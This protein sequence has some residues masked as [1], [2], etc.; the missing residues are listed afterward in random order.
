MGEAYSGGVLNGMAV[1][2][3]FDPL[4]RRVNNTVL[5]GSSILAR[6]TNGY[7]A[8]GRVTSVSDGTNS[9]T[10]S[11]FANSPLVDH[12]V[13]AHSGTSVMT[14]QNTY[15]HVNRLTGKNMAQA[16][17]TYN[18][19]YNAASQRTRVTLT[20]GDYWLWGFDALGQVTSGVKYFYDGTRYA[21]EQFGYSFDTIGNRLSTLAGGDATGSNLRST[22]YTNNLLNQI[23]S[24]NVPPFVDVLGLTLATNTVSVNGTNAYQKTEF[25]RYQAGANNAIAPQWVGINVTAPGQT[26]QSGSAYLAEN[27]ESFAYDADGN[28]T[29]D[30]H[31]TLTWDAENRLVS[32]TSLSG[33]PTASKYQ[34][35]FA[36]DYMGRRIQKMVATNN[37]TSYIPQYTNDYLYDGWNL[38]AIVSPAQ[39]LVGSFVW[40]TD[41]SGS[42]QGAGGVG[43]LVSENLV[44]SGVQFPVYDG[45]GNVTA[46]V[47]ATA[48]VVTANYEYG[49]FGE[50]IRATGPMAKLN[51]F[52]FSSK[53]NDDETDLLYYGYRYYNPSTGRW[54]SRD[55]ILEYAFTENLKSVP[56][57]YVD[58]ADDGNEYLFVR[59]NALSSY[60]AFGLCVKIRSGPGTITGGFWTSIKHQIHKHIGHNT[61]PTTDAFTLTC[62]S[63]RPYLFSWGLG[64][65]PYSPRGYETFPDWSLMSPISNPSGMGGT[66]II[67]VQVPSTTVVEDAEDIPNVYAVGC[68]T[69]SPY[70][71]IIFDSPPAPPYRPFHH[72]PYDGK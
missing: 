71:N 32:M 13:F 34:V 15:D 66:Y 37:G 54:L 70:A 42:M 17:L 3:G 5:T 36:Y 4:L 50:V 45:N 30:G 56:S 35:T 49:P 28:L 61:P 47:S 48:G 2:N 43:G 63:S 51:P 62:P 27:P 11:Y 59:N 7:N 24:R 29:G 9:A 14:N 57:S 53:Y 55:P 8:S 26:T 65:A 12:I 46:L 52:R 67:I 41:L 69:C 60:D 18:Y 58:D 6:M 31:W 23:N 19:Q 40:G 10:Y 44:G 20:N 68:C 16:F 38:V 33:A 72:G 1:T 25:Y 22:G 21:G 39:A 64:A